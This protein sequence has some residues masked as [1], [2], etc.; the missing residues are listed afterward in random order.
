MRGVPTNA[1]GLRHMVQCSAARRNA[2]LNVTQTQ[3]NTTR[4]IV[5]TYLPLRRPGSLDTHPL[6]LVTLMLLLP[7]GTHTWSTNGGGGG[8]GWQRRL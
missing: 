8:G 7:L 2:K 6:L 3:R 4:C 1:L 5:L